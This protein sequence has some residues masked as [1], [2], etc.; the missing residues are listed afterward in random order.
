MSRQRAVTVGV[1][2]VYAAMSVVS[3]GRGLYIGMPAQRILGMLVGLV[4]ALLV[5]KHVRR[6][7]KVG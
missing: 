5:I 2:Q 4:V 3:I 1:L 7:V 6:E